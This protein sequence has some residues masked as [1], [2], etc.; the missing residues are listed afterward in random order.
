[1]RNTTLNSRH[2]AL[3]MI[4]VLAV[5][6]STLF[7]RPI[8]AQTSPAPAEIVELARALKYNP[9][10]IYEYVYN[11]IETLPQY[12]SA[13]G[14]LGALL[15]GKG[16]PFDQAELMVALLQQSGLTASFQFGQIQLT[17][18][19]LTNWL[20]I[21]N[22]LGSVEF[23]IGSG[24]FSGTIIVSGTTVTAVQIG[25]AWVSVNIGG[26]NYVFDPSTKIYNRSA[27]IGLSALTSALGYSQS[28]F[29][30]DAE[31]GA[32]I[33]PNSIVGLNRTNVRNDLTTYANNLVGYIRTNSPAAATSDIVGGRTIAP[34]ALGTQLRQ[35]SLSY[36]VGTIST[37]PTM[38]SMYRTTLTLTLGSD[39][40]SNNFTPLASPITFNSSDIY[41]HRLVISFNSSSVPSLLLDGVTYVTASGTVPSGRQLTVRST[42]LHPYGSTFA[43]VTNSDQVRMT[44]F[45]SFIYLIGTGWGQVGRGTIEKHRKL[46]QDNIAANPGNPGAESVLGESLAMIGYTWLAERAQQEMVVDQVGGTNTI[47]QHA[48]GVV[49]T[50]AVGTSSGPY[51][52]LPI[53]GFSIVQRTARSTSTSVTPLESSAFFSESIF[54]SIAESGVLEQTQPGATAASTVKLLDTT[55]Q[56]GGKIFDINNSAVSGD[57]CTSYSS[58]GGIRSQ[59]SSYQTPDL[60]RIDSLVGFVFGTGCKSLSDPTNPNLRVITP[61]NGSINIGLYT[62]VGF[63]Q[64]AQDGSS[65]GSIITGGL[66]GGEPASDV[67]IPVIVDNT[68][69]SVSPAPNQSTVITNPQG[70]QGDAGGIVGVTQTSKE[71]INLVTGD[72]LNSTT[73]LT[74]GSQGMPFGLAFQRYYDS[75]TRSRNGPVGLGWTHNFA[76]TASTDSDAFAGMAAESPISGAVTIAATLVALDIL[77]AVTSNAKPL[78]RIVIASVLQRWLMDQLTT[79]IVAVAQPGYVEHFTRLADGSYNPPPG[80]ATVLTSSGGNFNYLAR[81]RQALAFDTAGN[82]KTLSN[83]AGTTITLNYS[84]SPEVLASATNNLGRALNFT[85][86]SGLLTRVSDGTGR[87]VSY[88]YDAASNLTGFTDPLGKTTTYA[89]DLPGRLTKIFYPANPNSAFVTNTYDSLGRVRTQAGGTNPPWQYFF[90]GARSEEDDPSGMQHV[91][92]TTPRGKTRADI[93][94]LQGLNLVSTNTFD[95]LDR[96]TSA[97]APE[98]KATGYTYDVNSNVLTVTATAKPGSGLSSLVT[99]YTYDPVFNKPVSITDPLLLVTTFSYDGFGNLASSTSDVGASP[100]F[101]A[102]VAFTYNNVGLALTAT[103]PLGTITQFTYDTFGNQTSVTRDINH[104]NQKRLAAFDAVGNTLSVTDPKG[105][106]T[107]LAY[108]AARRLT[109]TTA[110]NGLLASFTYDA[111]GQLLATQQSLYGAALRSTGT[112]YTLTGKPAATTDADNNKTIFAYDGLDRL[113]SATDAM[114]RVTTLGYDALSRQSKL[115]NAA[116][117]SAPLLQ[118]TYTPDGLLASLIDANNNT[119]NLAYDGFDR[120]S[121]TTYPL[122][123][124]ESVRS[125]EAFTYDNDSNVLS[126]KTRAGATISFTYDTLNRLLTKTPP[127]PGPT[128]TYGY[129]LT[130]RLTSALDTTSAAITPAAPPG[131]SPVQYAAA[132][133]YDVMN[134]PIGVSWSPA[135]VA[136]APTAF[137]VAF[138]H[139]YNRTNQRIGQTISDNSWVNYPAATPGTVSY[140][141][142]ALNR[143]TAVGAVS[144]SYD[145]NG[146]LTSDGTFT[147]G[148]D[149][150]NRLTSASGA[151]N[152]A[153]YTY[154][155]QGRRKSRTVNGTT[156]VSITDANNREVLEYDGS[157]G[158]IQRWYAYALG[159]NDV[160]NQMNVVAGTRATLLPDI[161]GSII[162]AQDSS[163]GALTKVGY[164]PY[165]KSASAGPF[166]FTGQRID[167][168]TSGLYYYR[169]R[170]YS[171]AL[172]R[173]LQVDP[174]GY[175]GG[176]NLYAYVGNDPLNLIDP[177][178]T[179]GLL[180]S[181]GAEVTAGASPY[182]APG[183]GPIPSGAFATGSVAVGI[184]SSGT[185]GVSTTYAAGAYQDP[186]RSNAVPDQTAQ[187]YISGFSAGKGPAI[188]FTTAE[189]NSDLRGV[190]NVSNVNLGIAQFQTSVTTNA[191]GQPVTTWTVSL[192]LCI[193]YA[194]YQTDTSASR[195]EAIIP[196]ANGS[197]SIIPPTNAGT[198]GST[199]A[200]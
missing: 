65:I 97:V 93:Q 112:T 40:A 73:D 38:P 100:H 193:G 188:S 36:A 39:D 1:M 4:S 13:K 53:N 163:S 117:Q 15:D 69:Q 143:Y 196:S 62:G 84:G 41:D 111:N 6:V 160:L 174:I 33:T 132:Y 57:D 35:T 81:N 56:A 42:I 130:G 140:T 134:R 168:E 45:A 200:K 128:V 110:P 167:L 184:F 76:I 29:I 101:N 180:F 115:F 12:G 25:W 170:H 103:D 16:T 164:L 7:V 83:P 198:T 104:L 146:N 11:N 108:D 192:C 66:S 109:A 182:Y 147:L 135:P 19:Q 139:S 173:F 149:A 77:N 124:G 47:Y 50:K 166:G 187:P 55:I 131:G 18:A 120:L 51:V 199:P 59:L 48:L 197:E 179:L 123:S 172:G 122:G 32:T 28:T 119:T 161:I 95:A 148:Y 43:N 72:Y 90:A 82:L 186:G 17:A 46:L 80:T 91:I 27:G 68:P 113:V 155:A 10:L 54:A 136:T 20:G 125:T 157:S 71:P 89:Y 22:T 152:T 176:A 127:S 63:F 94:D 67:P 181:F 44:P 137:S 142:D 165:G 126:R 102:R 151:G 153:A 14:P 78:D 34:L 75:G 175:S 87:S 8:W 92:Y 133:S 150:E 189:T 98:G 194:R 171:P 79:N 183:Q 21:D 26:T 106:V 31:S 30:S 96:L 23:T 156:T 177:T 85:Y 185:Y 178:G 24:G 37:Q 114:G 190:S 154:D 61:Q 2:T 158:A 169:A 86:A 162:A 5:L 60:L 58:S 9:D 64:I 129:D 118:K 49:G 145:G 138:G 52:D 141:A 191:A 159:P 3:R 121:T 195:S 74:V 107:K 99:T 88:T 70:S 116:V 144:P 105:N